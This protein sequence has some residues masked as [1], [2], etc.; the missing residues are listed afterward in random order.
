MWRIKLA[1]SP[2]LLLF[3]K[4][5][6]IYYILILN[7]YLESFNFTVLSKKLR[8]YAKSNGYIGTSCHKSELKITIILTFIDLITT[9]Y[10]FLIEFMV[11]FNIQVFFKSFPTKFYKNNYF[12]LSLLWQHFPTLLVKIENFSWNGLFIAKSSI[13]SQR[14]GLILHT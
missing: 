6:L 2:L 1:F 14:I 11:I 5:N 13:I 8:L 9:F 12:R 4:D 10:I 7:S 3:C